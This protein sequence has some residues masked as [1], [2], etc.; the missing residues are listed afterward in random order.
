MGKYASKVV[1]QA[2]KWVGKNEAD[3]THKEIIDIYNAHKPLARGYAVKYTDPWCATTTSAVAIV[4]G[5]TDIIPIECSCSKLIEIAKQMG[6][7]VEN[8]NRTPKPGELMLYD[9]DDNGKGDNI[10]GPE[11]IGIVEKCAGNTIT[12]IEGNYS[13]AVKRRYVAVNGKFIRGYIAPKYDAEPAEKE[14][15]AAYIPTVKAWQIAALADGFKFPKYG[16]D[17]EWGAECAS[18]ARKAVVKKRIIYTIKNLTKLVQKV[19]GV[20]VD[21]KC[22]KNTDAAIRAYQKKHGLTADG[23]VG[24]NTWKTIL[25][26]D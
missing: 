7:W 24:L 4:L 13:N 2:Q 25:N 5:Y 21:G 10:G 18:V 26:I 19:V 23:A 14:T 20:T 16:A 22:G 3:G 8:E 11:H 12:V 17:G 9:W 15:E 1:E 6:I